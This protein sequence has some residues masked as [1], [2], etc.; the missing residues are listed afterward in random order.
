LSGQ[1]EFN[2]DDNRH[3]NFCPTCGQ[4]VDIYKRALNSGMARSLISL[5]LN[6]GGQFGW[7]RI[8]GQGWASTDMTMLW[9]WGLMEEK[10]NENT[11][12]RN[13]GVWRPT[14]KGKNYVFRKIKVPKMVV[15]GPR[16]KRLGFE[17]EDWSIVDALGKNFN[18]YELM[19]L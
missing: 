13:S 5:V 11:A 14:S 8:R 12:K 19:S 2:F 3:G 4:L 10:I 6:S 7:V 15:L 16:N 18:Y 17:G 9:H 1:D